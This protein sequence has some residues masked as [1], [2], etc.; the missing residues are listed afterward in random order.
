MNHQQEMAGPGQ[1]QRIARLLDLDRG[2]GLAIVL[3][4]LG[5]VVARDLP[6]GNEWFGTVRRLVYL[7]HMQFFMFLTG[8][9]MMLTYRPVNGWADYRSWVGK[10]FSRLMPAFFGFGLLVLVGKLVA[11]RFLFV[12][13]VPEDFWGGL[14]ALVI[15]PVQSAANYL[16]YV[17]VVFIYYVLFPP[18]L[19]AVRGRLEW[20]LLAG[21]AMRWLP[22]SWWFAWHYVVEFAFI[23]FLG[24]W[25]GRH[26]ARYVALVDRVWPH[27]LAVFVG[28]LAI[29]VWYRLPPLVIGVISV[30]ALHGLCRAGWLAKST[31]LETLGWYTFSIYLMNTLVIGVLKGVILKITPWDGWRFWWIGPV[32]WVAGLWVPVV[33]KRY[34]LPRI[35]AINRYVG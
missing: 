24:A 30:P 6:A 34:V 1:A 3:V 23:F 35:P 21:L 29:S 8:L 10:K 11:Q 31:V 17:Y 13:N 16:W 27:L 33:I 19:A 26:Y 5:H 12:D 22:D 9:V 32:L 28:V 7:F 4:V 25:V 14:L 18:L 20:L 15:L 2:K